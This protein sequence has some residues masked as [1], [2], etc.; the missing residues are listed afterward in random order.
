[1]CQLQRFKMRFYPV[2]SIPS[3]DLDLAASGLVDRDLDRAS[4]IS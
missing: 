4:L 1:M 2:Y 3:L